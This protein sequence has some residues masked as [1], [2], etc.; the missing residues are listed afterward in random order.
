MAQF[1]H[2]LLNG[3]V[4][5]IKEFIKFEQMRSVERS[6]PISLSDNALILLLLWRINSIQKEEYLK[7]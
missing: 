4:F 2:E 6:K 7:F 5:R 3:F 1:P